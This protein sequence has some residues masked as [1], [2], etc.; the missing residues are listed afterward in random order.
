M[1]VTGLVLGAVP[2]VLE[3]LK[4]Y[5]TLS[6]ICKRF[7][8]CRNG[9]ERLIDCLEIQKCIFDNETRLLLGAA[10]G[11]NVARDMIHDLEHPLWNEEATM[12]CVDNLLGDSK[13]A[14]TIA[15]EHVRESMISLETKLRD[16]R[17]DDTSGRLALDKKARKEIRKRFGYAFSREELEAISD[18]VTRS[19]EKYR[20]LRSQILEIAVMHSQTR[21]D[22]GKDK[23]AKQVSAI[24]I[25]TRQLCEMLPKACLL[26]TKHFAHFSLEPQHTIIH[27]TVTEIKFLIAYR[28]LSQQLAQRQ[29]DMLWFTI[30]WEHRPIKTT[31]DTQLSRSKRT[32]SPTLVTC[33]GPAEK[34]HKCVQFQSPPRTPSPLSVGVATASSTSE[35]ATNISLTSDLCTRLRSGSKCTD[36]TCIGWLEDSTQSRYRMYPSEGPYQNAVTTGA[37]SL[38]AF[39]TTRCESGQSARQIPLLRRVQVA[40]LLASAMLNYHSTPLTRSTWSSRDIFL[41]GTDLS[42]FSHS[43]FELNAFLEVSIEHQPDEAGEHEASNNLTPF[44]PNLTLF[45][46]AVILLELAYQKPLH[47]MIEASDSAPRWPS[48]TNVVFAMRRLSKGV[49]RFLGI[50]YSKIIAKC[51][52]CEFAEG[53]DLDSVPLQRAIQRDVISELDRLVKDF[54]QTGLY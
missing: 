8:K 19:T 14:I 16:L 30:E 11:S 17:L 33:D 35:I 25:V 54:E 7:R 24:Q 2:I 27:D 26:H 28:H 15:S 37:Q 36:K 22:L 44:V 39:F 6:R 4:Q 46:I 48:H 50:H 23:T 10:L 29:H 47:E 34:R 12:T 51:L 31:S 5:Q 43:S 21:P 45:G 53:T 41:Y 49:S 52:E 3:V 9:V 32:L 38:A 1:E 20:T 42:R 13:I 18:N 40:R